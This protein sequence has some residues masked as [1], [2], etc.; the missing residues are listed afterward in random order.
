MNLRFGAPAVPTSMIAETI[1]FEP[2]SLP[3]K[4]EWFA[5]IFIAKRL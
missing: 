4:G 1:Q 2:G 5:R 3:W